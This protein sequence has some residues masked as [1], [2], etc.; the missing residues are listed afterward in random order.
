M[1]FQR[2]CDDII[3]HLQLQLCFSKFF[4]IFALLLVFF[5]GRASFN[6]SISLCNCC[7]I[8][9][10]CS[11]SKP[12]WQPSEI[13]NAASC[14]SARECIQ[15]WFLLGLSFFSSSFRSSHC[16][17]LHRHFQLL[18]CKNMRCLLIFWR[19]YQRLHPLY[20]S[21]VIFCYL[22]MWAYCRANLPT[23]LWDYRSCFRERLR[24][25]RK[26]LR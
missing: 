16:F 7:Q 18:I 22:R 14:C 25:L 19:L 17:K 23:L 8:W 1:L 15:S 12:C 20:Q 26:F 4:R 2:A 3:E 10:S 13:F 21:A 9:S 11:H 5:V 24:A 6:S